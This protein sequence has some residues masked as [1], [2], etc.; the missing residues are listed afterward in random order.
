MKHLLVVVEK[1]TNVAVMDLNISNMY[2]NINLGFR[3]IQN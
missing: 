3:L 1:A 2:V